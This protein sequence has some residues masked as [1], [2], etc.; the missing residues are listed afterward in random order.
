MVLVDLLECQQQQTKAAKPR[1]APPNRAVGRKQH[2]P[3]GETI[4]REKEGS[5]TQK[6]RERAPLL[7]A[8][9]AHSLAALLS[10]NAA[11]LRLFLDGAAG[12]E[13]NVIELKIK[14]NYVN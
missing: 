13:T 4:Q 14:L 10:R 12:K 8:G 3:Q 5:I 2:H 11:F 1:A 7:L 6:E 9:A